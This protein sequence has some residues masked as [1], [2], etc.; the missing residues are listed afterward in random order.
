[1]DS[2]IMED[3][4]YLRVAGQYRRAIQSGVLVPGE[5]LPSVRA[6]MRLHQVSLSTALQ[7]C[8]SLEDEGLLEARP[9]SG[10]FVLK[11]RRLVLQAEAI[12]A[13]FPAGTRLNMPS[14]GMLLWVEMPGR[15]SSSEVFNTALQEGI[16][17]APG[18]MFSNAGRFDHCLR[19]SCGAP[20]SAHIET[21]LKRLAQIV[22]AGLD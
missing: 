9:R 14:G 1:M 15:R 7:A 18:M 5:R 10:Y 3:L 8:R 20:F 11:P 21:A 22:A 13:H 12:A 4:L 6:L 17:V 16:R 2:V 19:I